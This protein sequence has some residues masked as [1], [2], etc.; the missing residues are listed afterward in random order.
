MHMLLFLKEQYPTSLGSGYWLHP[1]RCNL[2]RLFNFA[3]NYLFH[4]SVLIAISKI[5]EVYELNI[6]KDIVL[7]QFISLMMSSKKRLGEGE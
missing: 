4:S 2:V 5:L 6:L 3:I 1:Y 7:S